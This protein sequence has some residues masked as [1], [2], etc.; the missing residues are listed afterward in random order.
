M[1][2]LGYIKVIR[3]PQVVEQQYDK[4]PQGQRPLKGPEMGKN[5]PSPSCY[6]ENKKGGGS[7]IRNQN[8]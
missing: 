7:G 3:D 6:V 4:S 1:L 8:W 2:N 5:F